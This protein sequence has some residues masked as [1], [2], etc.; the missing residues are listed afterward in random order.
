MHGFVAL[1]A[2][3]GFGLPQSVDGSYHRLVDALDAAL[4]A[5]PATD[6]PAPPE[7]PS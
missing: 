1:E 7:A 2:A 4:A 6:P 5:W 3:G